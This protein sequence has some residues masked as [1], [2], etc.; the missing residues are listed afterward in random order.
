MMVSDLLDTQDMVARTPISIL[1][2]HLIKQQINEQLKT[3]M[4]SFKIHQNS[5]VL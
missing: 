5:M 2:H 3:A 4:T 1:Q